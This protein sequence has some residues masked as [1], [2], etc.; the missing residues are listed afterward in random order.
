MH[1][2]KCLPFWKQ[3]MYSTLSGIMNKAPALHGCFWTIRYAVTSGVCKIMLIRASI[4]IGSHIFIYFAFISETTA[5]YCRLCSAV[6]PV[7]TMA[8]C[9]WNSE[10]IHKMITQADL[11]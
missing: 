4:L 1:Y 11:I 7:L 10:Y 6:L 3:S 5:I 2:Y 8:L 9:I